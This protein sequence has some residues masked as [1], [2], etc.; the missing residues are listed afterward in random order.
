VKCFCLSWALTSP[1]RFWIDA[2]DDIEYLPSTYFDP[3]WYIKDLRLHEATTWSKER[4]H[5]GSFGKV[6]FHSQPEAWDYRDFFP[7]AFAFHWHNFY[8]K[9]PE[10]HSVAETFPDHFVS[11]QSRYTGTILSVP[12]QTT[13][14]KCTSRLD[15]AIVLY[16][17]FYYICTESFQG[18][19]LTKHD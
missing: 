19:H 6:F 3:A 18:V 13:L 8:G 12:N 4:Y 1:S 5:L 17:Q 11:Q 2:K 16:S 15:H 10:Q 14:N 7:G 9:G